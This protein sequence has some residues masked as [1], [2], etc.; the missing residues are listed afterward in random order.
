MFSKAGLLEET[1]GEGKTENNDR[2]N[3][4]EIHHVGKITEHN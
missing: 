2:V 1:L 4:T 3:N